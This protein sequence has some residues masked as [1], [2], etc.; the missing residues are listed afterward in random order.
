MNQNKNRKQQHHQDEKIIWR[1]DKVQELL[2][3]GHTNHSEIAAIMQIPRS[4]ITKDVIFL[5]EQAKQ[6]VA[7]YIDEKLPDEYEKCLVGLTAILKDAWNISQNAQENKEKI[8]ALELAKS[9]YQ[10]KLDLLTNATV[11]GDALKFMTSNKN[12]TTIN[13]EE[14]VGSGFS[15]GQTIEEKREETT[16][17][18][19][20]VF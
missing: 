1:R 8:S 5:R 14:E 10:T 4:T 15:K 17:T 11:L 13:K 3:K 16:N 12:N 19:N 9:C 18:I 20:Q 6:N 7:H 2:V